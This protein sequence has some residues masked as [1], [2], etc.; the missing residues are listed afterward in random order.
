MSRINKIADLIERNLG[1]E[2][3]RI[4][5]KPKRMSGEG[6]L[7]QAK[8]CGF[9]PATVFDVGAAFGEWTQMCSKIFPQARYLLFEPLKEYRS[10][11]QK[12]VK[13]L[14]QARYFPLALGA[15][16]GQALINVHQ[17]WVGSS[18]LK[19][20]EGSSVD[21]HRRAV[22]VQRLDE[23]VAQTKPRPPY[24]IK[25]DVQGA[26]L[27][28]LQGAGKTLEKTDYIILEVCLFE[29]MLGGSTFLEVL[30]FMQKRDFVLYDVLSLGYRPLDLALHQLD[31]ALVKK[32]S[33]LRQD[34]RFCSRGQR[35]DQD[36]KIRRENFFKL[37]S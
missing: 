11:L 2:I 14:K 7:A 3:R 34:H 20:R 25:L 27:N 19:E 10:R 9:S 23:V 6:G 33:C 16:R 28:V 21:G 30:E 29:T 22:P 31:L 36:Q 18:F 13:H 8:Q 24:L 17:D 4:S 32:K 35:I 37:H 26:E 15:G 12:L 1:L 5:P